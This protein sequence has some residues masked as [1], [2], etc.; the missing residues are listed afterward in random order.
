M[1]SLEILH[2]NDVYRVTKQKIQGS[3]ETI[4]VTQFGE[5][6]DSLRD[7]WPKRSDGKRDG[8]V[9][10]S[11]DVFSPSVESTVTR[12]SHMVPVMNH[13][14]PDV[15]LT[16]NHDFDF[17]Y[18]HLCK[19]IDDCTFPWV[20][21]NIVD[22]DV[23]S[24]PDKLTRY[25]IF[26]RNGVRVGV[27][28]LVEEEWIATVASWPSNFKYE[29]MAEVAKTLSQELR[30]PEGPHKCDI[31]LALTHARLL[32]DI[33]LAKEVLAHSKLTSD[34]VNC[35][36]VDVLFGGHD[37]M[38]YI[39]HGAQSWRNYDLK[40]SCLGSEEDDGVFLVKSGTD[41]RDL[42]ELTLELEDTP[43]GSIRRIRH[44]VQPSQP[45]SPALTKI[46]KSQL[47]SV[48]STLS[49]P[50]CHTLTEWNA[51]SDLV[52]TDES[53]LGD[54]MA[55]VLRHAYDDALCVKGGGPADGVLICG[56]TLR[57]DSVYGPGDITLGD[58]LEILPFEDPIVVQAL[59]GETIW[60]ALEAGLSTWPAQEG[61]FP[62]VSGIRIEWDSRL[63]PGNRV[64]GIWL[65]E[66]E[67]ASDGSVQSKN[68]QPIARDASKT[69]RIVT[70]EYMAAG[71]DGYDALKG[72]PFLIDDE[73]GVIMSSIV[74]RY[75]LGKI[76]IMIGT[77]VDHA[78]E[79]SQYIHTFKAQKSE[80]TPSLLSSSS[81][82]TISKAKQ[83]WLKA[84][85]MIVNFERQRAPTGHSISEIGDALRIAQREHMTDIDSFDGAK[86]RCGK[87]SQSKAKTDLVVVSPATDGRLKDL[88]RT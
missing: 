58:L 65:A 67:I 83:R 8:L 51:K 70:R 68:G 48:S 69:Y 10:F 37:H 39:G 17:G 6:L 81:V 23:S 7:N 18:P 77:G 66:Q 63:T 75:I 43:E 56:G 79:G 38:Y 33:K 30:D 15:S 88:G 46:I 5:L 19:L 44:S 76:F 45:S 52:R 4:D 21:S 74:R 35:H 61:R 20:L 82:H 9:L 72:K 29:S 16:G 28:G 36:G 14:S 22:T 53:A 55:D 27:I 57:G 64:K 78:R 11:G 24:T 71:H 84:A 32:N 47:D 26:E 31:I 86:A 34:S 50:I 42:S 60:N 12:G 73:N 54:W 3:K 49:E 40:S 2:F 62:I 13:I 25:Q 85:E 80:N 41:F 87:A 59:D 1:S